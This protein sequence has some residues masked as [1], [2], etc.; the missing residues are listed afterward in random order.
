MKT[1]SF[2]KAVLKVQSINVGEDEPTHYA[3]RKGYHANIRDECNYAFTVEE[4]DPILRSAFCNPLF[5]D[6][7]VVTVD[8]IQGQWLIKKYRKRK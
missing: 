8:D 4:F 7:F 6:T 3:I 2:K 5:D 1:Y